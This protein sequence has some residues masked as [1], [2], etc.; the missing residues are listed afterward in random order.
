LS[1]RTICRSCVIT[2]E[3]VWETCG[4]GDAQVTWEGVSRLYDDDGLDDMHSAGNNQIF[5][6][7]SYEIYSILIN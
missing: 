4:D 1:R 2:D 3:A 5:F 7:I 6:I